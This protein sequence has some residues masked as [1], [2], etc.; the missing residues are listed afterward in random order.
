MARRFKTLDDLEIAGKVILVRADLNVPV[1]NGEVT[2]DTRIRSIVPTIQAILDR[3]G[4]AAVLS[5]FGRPKGQV[6]PEAS[7]EPIAAHLGAA[8]GMEVGFASDCIEGPAKEAIAAHQVTLLENLRFHPG[9][10]ANADGF[11]AQLA[12]LGDGYVADAFS[13]AHRAHAS[14]E[15]ITRHLPSAAGL[16]MM[17]ELDALEKALTNPERPVAALVGGAKISTKLDILSTLIE[18]V[19]YLIIGGGMANTFLAAKGVAVGKSLGLVVRVHIV[20]YFILIFLYF[21]MFFS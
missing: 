3:G 13:V 20:Q 17:E 16:S 1:V 19:D 5:H 6:V 14:T 18:K 15:A 12:E 21:A 7:L 4:K 10:E 2:D 8:L 11:A 9:E